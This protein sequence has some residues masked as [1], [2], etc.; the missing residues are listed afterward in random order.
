MLI[1]I[2]ARSVVTRGFKEEYTSIAGNSAQIVRHDVEWKR[3]TAYKTNIF[4]EK[5]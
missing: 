5:W 1:D 4:R 2:G 3:E